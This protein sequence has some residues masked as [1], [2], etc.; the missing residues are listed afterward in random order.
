MSR[1]KRDVAAIFAS[2]VMRAAQKQ[3]FRRLLPHPESR[4]PGYSVHLAKAERRGK[5][6]E[7]QRRMRMERE[8]N[9]GK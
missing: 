4:P 5:T 9:G 6:A 1:R 7:E 8:G 3:G 2:L